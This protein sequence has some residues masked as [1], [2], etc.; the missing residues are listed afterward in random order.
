MELHRTLKSDQKSLR[1]MGL[2]FMVFV[3]QS[4]CIGFLRTIAEC[5]H[6]VSEG[7]LK[8]MV[9]SILIP[10]D[11][12]QSAMVLIINLCQRPPIRVHGSMILWSSHRPYP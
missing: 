10:Q 9:F 3:M 1:I 2:G 5:E 7:T 8:Q 6:A 12:R 11:R 4:V